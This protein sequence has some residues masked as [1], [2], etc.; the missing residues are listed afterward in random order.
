MKINTFDAPPTCFPLHIEIQDFSNHEEQVGCQGAPLLD[1]LLDG[2]GSSG[3]AFNR[4][5][6][7]CTLEKQLDHF[8]EG[9]RK[10]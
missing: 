6:S 7:R 10:A 1:P 9:R 4:Y 8:Y 2:K 5:P 3:L